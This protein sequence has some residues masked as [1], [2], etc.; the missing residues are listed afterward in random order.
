MHPDLHEP[1]LASHMCQ[2]EHVQAQLG[3]AHTG[4]QQPDAKP[5]ACMCSWLPQADW[6]LASLGAKRLHLASQSSAVQRQLES[7]DVHTA[8]RLLHGLLQV[9]C[10][11]SLRHAH[12]ILDALKRTCT[13]VWA[14]L[15][16]FADTSERLQ[17][18]CISPRH[19]LRH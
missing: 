4:M 11:G 14:K 13:P 15:G 8:P 10:K 7:A 16:K 19:F 2:Q 1:S 17:V 3:T 18:A 5:Q 6:L 12:D 9:P